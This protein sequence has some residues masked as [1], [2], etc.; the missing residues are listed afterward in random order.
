MPTPTPV[1]T[2]TPKPLPTPIVYTVKAGDN[3]LTIAKRFKT[4][5]RSIAYWNRAAYPSLDPESPKYDPNRIEV[6][7]KLTITP[8]VKNEGPGES[9]VTDRPARRPRSASGRSNHRRPTGPASSSRTGR[10]SR[11]RSA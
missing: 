11:T 5:G 2:P 9:P 4:T 6:G 7:W 10:A 3:L 1:P 8:G